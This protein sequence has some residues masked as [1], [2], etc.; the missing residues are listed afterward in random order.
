MKK[1]L[2]LGI[3]VSVGVAQPALAQAVPGDAAVQNQWFTGTLEAPSPALPKAGILEVEPYAIVTRTHGA[4]DMTGDYRATPNVDTFTSVMAVKYGIT[5]RISVQALPSISHVFNRASQYTGFGDLPIELEYR[6]S[7]ANNKTGFPSV[8]FALGLNVPIGKH[9]NLRTASSGFG[10]GAYTLKQQV[11]LQSLFDTPGG[12]PMRFRLF[13]AAYEP[14]GK[15]SVD[16]VSVYGTSQ[17]FTGRVDPGVSGTL[18][19]GGGYA[20]DR[21]W[22]IAMDLVYKSARGFTLEGT[23]AL[24]APFHSRSGRSS[25]LSWAP[26]LEYNLSGNV[27]IIAGVDFSLAGH[28]SSAYFAPQI[29]ISAGL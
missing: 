1:T 7:D 3:A 13:A 24:N 17:G 4:Y 9:D 10:S 20:F 16:N 29:A 5:D 12:H 6:I 21:R 14:I 18:G 27:G 25:T 19:I 8:T 26:A 28:N 22:V 2:I 11:L 23:D 15:T